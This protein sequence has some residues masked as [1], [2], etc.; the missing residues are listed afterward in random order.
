[1]SRSARSRRLI[2]AAFCLLL[3][4]S[5]AAAAAAPAS[6]TP[7]IGIGEHDARMFGDPHWQ[8]LGARPVRV[9]VAWDVLQRKQSRT[10]LD[11]YMT[12]ARAAG[13]EVLVSFGRSR[14]A[15]RGWDLPSTARMAQIFQ[16][17]RARYPWVKQYVTWNEANHCSQPTCRRP[18]RVAE[19]HDAMRRR[20]SSCQIVAADVLDNDGM[21]AWIARF[22]KAAKTR[23]TIWGLHNY[24]DANRFRTMGT[25]AFLKATKGAVWFTETGGVVWRE[26]ARERIRFAGKSDKHAATATKWVF[27]LAALSPRVKRVYFYNWLPGPTWDSGLMDEHGRPRPAYDVIRGWLA[28]RAAKAGA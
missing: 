1:V 10:E 19:Y 5:A 12:A 14:H 15:G 23:I 11:H 18:E 25:K 4:V 16:K 2:R 28:R 17:F 7:V 21:T 3:A 9:V 27:K 22:R 8:A 20:C 26:N 13:A 24:V 6:A